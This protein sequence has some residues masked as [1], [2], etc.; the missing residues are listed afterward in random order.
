MLLL[1]TLVTLLLGSTPSH[2]LDDPQ[3]DYDWVDEDIMEKYLIARQQDSDKIAAPTVDF[4]IYTRHNPSEPKEFSINTPEGFYYFVPEIPTYIFVHGWNS[5]YE[6]D[7]IQTMVSATLKAIDCNVIVADWNRARS[8]D[9]VS[10]VIA[11]PRTGQIIATMLDYTKEVYKLSFET[12]TIIGHSLGAHVAGSVGKNVK[13]GKIHKIIGLDPAKPLFFYN[14][15][16]ERLAATDAIY[17]QAIHTNIGVLGFVKPIGKADFYVN[18]GNYQPGCDSHE[19]SHIRVTS[20]YAEVL[21]L[22]DFGAIRCDNFIQ[23]KF[24][25]C[26]SNLSEVRMGA[27]DAVDEVEGIFYVPVRECYPFGVQNLENVESCDNDKYFG[28]YDS[29]SF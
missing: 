3:K 20:Y 28:K 4:F 14:K 21:E 22:N 15:P 25:N 7:F 12:L 8:W 2:S 10:S 17:V 23:A 19:C 18:G 1:F 24:H 16:E 26:G 6:S 27:R 9:Y 29:V 13:N 5:S 11:I